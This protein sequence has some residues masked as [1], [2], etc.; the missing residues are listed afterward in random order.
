MGR[1]RTPLIGRRIG[2][3]LAATAALAIPSLGIAAAPPV[4]LASIGPRPMAVAAGPGFRWGAPMTYDARDGYAV[5]FGGS[6]QPA[7][8]P[9]RLFDDTWTYVGG[10]WTKLAP[11]FHPSFRS[12][13]SLAYDAKSGY[14]LLFGGANNT[15][16]FSDTWTFAGGVWLKLHP[17]AAPSPRNCASMVWDAKDGYMVLFGGDNG[18]GFL[19]ND[20][21]SYS[22]GHWTNITPTVSP[23]GRRSM[24]MTYDAARGDVVLFGGLGNFGDLADTWTFTNGTWTQLFPSTAPG[25]RVAPGMTYD[26]KDKYVLLFGGRDDYTGTVLNDTWTF[27][28][29]GWSQLNPRATPPARNWPAIA[30]DVKDG[31]V[32][33]FG[34]RHTSYGATYLKDTW[35]F[36]GGRWY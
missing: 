13:V 8:G 12:C 2:I 19:L 29:T 26:G 1:A 11:A 9:T 5:L 4:H 17:A 6:V 23:P 35:E 20:T 18:K 21:W 36:S 3:L 34:G 25:V 30:Y 7:N 31:Y 16:E 24:G 15:R 28:G 33:M 22:R 32:V 14:V 10:N 27:N